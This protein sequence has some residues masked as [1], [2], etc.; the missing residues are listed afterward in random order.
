MPVV[1]GLCQGGCVPLGEPP[2][3]EL[4]EAATDALGR[5]RSGVVTVQVEQAEVLI[6]V[7]VTATVQHDTT[8]EVVAVIANVCRFTACNG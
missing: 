6:L 8:G 2:L 1:Q 5:F 3:G 4:L 7:V